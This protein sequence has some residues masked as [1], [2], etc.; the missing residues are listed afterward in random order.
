MKEIKVY[1]PDKSFII[2]DLDKYEKKNNSLDY[3][4]KE[5]DVIYDCHQS[6]YGFIEKD[7]WLCGMTIENG[8]PNCSYYSLKNNKTI[9]K[10]V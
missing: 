1:Y 10:I 5:G 6:I 4:L 8:C 9:R 3:V 2:I 7:Q